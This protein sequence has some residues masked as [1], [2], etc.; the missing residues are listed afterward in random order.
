MRMSFLFS[1]KF[2]WN[3]SGLALRPLLANH[4]LSKLELFNSYKITGI[5]LLF[6]K[7]GELSSA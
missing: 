7:N 1:F 4:S 5:V 2:K 3:L 6:H